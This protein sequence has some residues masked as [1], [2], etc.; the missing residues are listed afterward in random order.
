MK[1]IAVA[2]L[3]AA[4]FGLSVSTPAS[5]DVVIYQVSGSESDY[6]YPSFGVT[7][8]GTYD[9]EISVSRD[10]DLYFTA[11][12]NTHYDVYLAPPP[13]P[14]AENLEGSQNSGT[15]SE[16][17]YGSYKKYTIVMPEPVISYFA[18]GSQY[19]YRG[20]QPGTPL[21]SEYFYESIFGRFYVFPN[22]PEPFDF[23]FTVTKHEETAPVPEPSA[24][25]LMIL[26]FGAVGGA[27]RAR[28]R[29]TLAA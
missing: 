3:G 2:A 9:F 26:G 12:I 23:T 13:R 14:H 17:S 11:T 8:P 29:E 28:R 16:D 20:I 18:A 4:A 10:I 24:W 7:D 15:W 25:A 6:F 21:Y 1:R 27:I 19:L 5:A 22:S